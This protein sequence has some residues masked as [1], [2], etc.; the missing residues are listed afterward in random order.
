VQPQLVRLVVR[1]ERQA[2]LLG[3]LAR[4][5]A[6]QERRLT[7]SLQALVKWLTRRPAERRPPAQ[8]AL[9]RVRFAL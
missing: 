8:A 7:G 2:V 3:R 4:V 6:Q 5:R 9:A 1:L